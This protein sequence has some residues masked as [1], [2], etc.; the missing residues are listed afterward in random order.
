MSYIRIK[1]IK[2]K[3]YAYRQ[4]SVRKGKKVKTISEYL[5]ALFWAPLAAM[6]PGKP[7]GYGGHKST[8]K[9]A[10]KHQE[11]YNREKFA[12]EMPLLR[13]LEG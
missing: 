8:D 9:R 3:Q 5:G 2:G 11:N 6:S 1:T 10:N 4:T 12:K 7:G 13:E